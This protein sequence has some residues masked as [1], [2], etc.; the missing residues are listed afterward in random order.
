MPLYTIPLSSIEFFGLAYLRVLGL[1]ATLPL[2]NA[3]EIPNVLRGG[4]TAVF[5]LAAVIGLADQPHTVPASGGGFVLAAVTEFLLGGLAGWL[6][7]WVSEAV[8]IGAQLTGFQMGFAIVNVLDPT[9]GAAVA[10][11]AAFQARVALMVF[12][13]GGLFRPFLEA[14]AASF[15]LIPVGAVVLRGAQAPLVTGTMG[16][17]FRTAVVL[18]AAPI[19]AL[20]ITK[21]AMGLL[22][23]TV[24]QMNI[25]M[26]GFP[27]TIGI[28][29][30]VTAAAM[31]YFVRGV[32]RDFGQAL[33]RVVALLH[34]AAP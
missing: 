17:A 32:D 30:L 9:T 25:F 26:V 24:P 1:M 34:S 33:G 4:L 8:V 19:V 7:S 5:T 3:R 12:V 2:F 13:A 6:V 11:T 23:R 16:L 15:Q 31:P 18:S 22:A 28:G 10:E 29:V 21:V 20:L 14:L 27:L